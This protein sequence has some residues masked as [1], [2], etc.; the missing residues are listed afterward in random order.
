MNRVYIVMRENGIDTDGHYYESSTSII[1]VRETPEEAADL[2]KAATIAWH[3]EEKPDHG[4]Y[5]EYGDKKV[6]YANGCDLWDTFWIEE[7]AMPGD[8]LPKPVCMYLNEAKQKKQSESWLEK[9]DIAGF[10]TKCYQ[11]N[12]ADIP[13]IN[14]KEELNLCS[15]LIADMVKRGAPDSEIGR[16]IR[17]SM[18]VLDTERMHLNWAKAKIDEGIDTLVMKYMNAENIVKYHIKDKSDFDRMCCKGDVCDADDE[19]R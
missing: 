1:G 16:A 15:N 12:E 7:M 11:T 18:V 3:G 17:Y 6:T 5:D 10:D 2:L 4:I 14:K 19:H 13:V 8:I 9:Y